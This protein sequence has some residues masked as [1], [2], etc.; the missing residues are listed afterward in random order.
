MLTCYT[1]LLLVSMDVSGSVHVE[2]L[3]HLRN[4]DVEG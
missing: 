4:I 3:I 1:G 2:Y